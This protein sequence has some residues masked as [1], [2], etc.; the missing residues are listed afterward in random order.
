MKLVLTGYGKMGRL[1][2]EEAQKKGWEV[3]AALDGPDLGRLE[4][5]PSADLV[6]DFSHPDTLKPLEGYVRR[7]RTPLLSGTTGYSEAQLERLRQLGAAAP[8][9]Y[10]ANY[11][12]GV[13]LLRRMLERFGPVLL[14]S[15]EPELVEKH[16]RQKADA[17][18]GTA[19]LLADALD[20]DRCLR[21]VYGREGFC[22]ERSQDEMGLFSVRGGTVAGEHTLYFFGQDETLSLAHS[23][24][25]R[26]IFAVGAVKAAALL[27]KR[28]PGFYTLD[29]ILFLPEKEM[30]YPNA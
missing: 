29:E 15:F 1:I 8:V 20:P 24:A 28:S 26:R 6:I 11:S 9:L 21:R 14:E 22:G 2:E 19:V 12:L 16:H 27:A 23:A 4:D 17:P 5:L 13:A 30:P 25:S 18:S 10:S 7:T 3:L